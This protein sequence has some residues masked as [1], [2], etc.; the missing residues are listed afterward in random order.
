MNAQ[1]LHFRRSVFQYGSQTGLTKKDSQ[2]DRQNLDPKG[3]ACEADDEMDRRDGGANREVERDPCWFSSL[4][5]SSAG[6]SRRVVSEQESGFLDCGLFTR[7]ANES[8]NALEYP[9][10]SALQH[11][12]PSDST[13]TTML[14]II[15][16]G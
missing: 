7:E 2:E 15:R 13:S 1:I 4:S 12:A 10:K 5:A 3:K 11:R 14:S 9:A 8:F 16:P 6:R